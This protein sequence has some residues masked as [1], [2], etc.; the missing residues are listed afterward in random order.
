M[1]RLLI[2]ALLCVLLASCQAPQALPASAIVSP[3]APPTAT[4]PTL[5]PTPTTTLTPTPTPTPDPLA[6]W[7]LTE[8]I[9]Q[10]LIVAP[11]AITDDPTAVTSHAKQAYAAV[12]VG[13]FILFQSNMTSQAQVKQL[14]KDLRHLSTQKLW[15]ATDLEGGGVNRFGTMA[16]TDVPWAAQMAKAGTP[17][18]V[19]ATYAEMGRQLREDWDMDVN[20]APVADVF[21]NPNNTVIGRRAF[22]TTGEQAAPYVAAA[23]AGLHDA[24]VLCAIKHFPGHGDTAQ[25]SHAGAATTDKTLAEMEAMEF[26][27]FVAGIDASADMVMVAHVLTPNVTTDGLPATLSREMIT[28]VLREK[29]GYNGVVITDAMNM[30]AITSFYTADEAAVMALEAGVDIVLMPDNCIT[31]MAGIQAAVAEG[32]LTEARID[33][34]VRRVLALKEGRSL[35]ATIN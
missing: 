31:A 7:T 16:F 27:P 6:G 4:L 15:I 26:L 17:D 35:S 21:S 3:I 20:F 23:V 11:E 32:R 22:G 19:R 24:A 29:L 1:A 25:D 30:K 5:P 8:K 14:T 28:G 9:G 33:E 18:D 34:S 2:T 13:G 12:P 10:L